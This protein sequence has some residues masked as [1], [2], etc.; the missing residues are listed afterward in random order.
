[1]VEHLPIRYEALSSIPPHDTHLYSYTEIQFVRGMHLVLLT[2]VSL[3][4]STLELL[5][6]CLLNE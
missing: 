6:E 3:V 5:K 4:L 1:M 2:Y